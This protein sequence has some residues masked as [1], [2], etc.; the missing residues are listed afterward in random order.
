MAFAV[1]HVRCAER[2]RD[3]RLTA[4]KKNK[5][6]LMGVIFIL[7]ILGALA[8]AEWYQLRYI[9]RIREGAYVINSPEIAK[10]LTRGIEP[11]DPTFA[12]L[13]VE[14]GEDIYQRGNT[15]YVGLDRKKIEDAYPFFTNDGNAVMIVRDSS[16]L[17]DDSFEEATTYQG[18]Y[19]SAGLSFNYD[20]VQADDADYLFLK[21]ENGLY[22][23]AQPIRFDYPG[24]DSSV[25][26]NSVFY[27]GKDAVRYY[28]VRKGDSLEYGGVPTV[29]MLTVTIG[30]KTYSYEQFLNLLGIT[31]D[32][33]AWKK[34]AV[35]KEETAAA[36]LPRPLKETE[37]T[38]AFLPEEFERLEETQ[39]EE[40]EES[41]EEENTDTER[42]KAERELKN[43]KEKKKKEQKKKQN[44]I[45]SKNTGGQTPSKDTSSPTTE[46]P[47]DP[48][49]EIP[50]ISGNDVSGSDVSGNDAM[51]RPFAE[52]G[53][54][55]EDIYSVYS[56]LK[57]SDPSYTLKRVEVELFW[58]ADPT[59]ANIGDKDAYQ[60][61][62][63]KSFRT[64][65]E[66]T[67]DNL[68][69]DT[70]MYAR[71]VV[72]YSVEGETKRY[73]F[74][75][76]LEDH[77]DK[78]IQTKPLSEMDDIYVNFKDE[79]PMAGEGEEPVKVPANQMQV[80]SFRISGPNPNVL[81]RVQSIQIEVTPTDE[82][83]K[84]NGPYL[85]EMIESAGLFQRNYFYQ[86][87]GGTWISDDTKVYLPSSM[88]FDYSIALYDRFGNAIKRVVRGYYADPRLAKEDDS[89]EGEQP[90]DPETED[91]GDK[92]PV[93]A[94]DW[95]S[96]KSLSHTGEEF[97]KY[98]YGAAE[99]D[100][101]EL[102]GRSHTSRMAP[103]VTIAQKRFEDNQPN[104]DRAKFEIGIRDADGTILSEYKG[105]YYLTILRKNAD[106]VFVPFEFKSYAADGVTPVT[107]TKQITEG[108]ETKEYTIVKIADANFPSGSAAD[109]ENSTAACIY[110]ILGLTAGCV[111]EIRVYGNYDLAD[112]VCAETVTPQIW[113]Q[114]FLTADLSTYGNVAYNITNKHIKTEIWPDGKTYPSEENPAVNELS[115]YES[116]TAQ[117]ISIELNSIQ[118]SE[119]L[120]ELMTDMQVKM[121][122]KAESGK[123]TTAV[124]SAA[125]DV[126]KM[127]EVMAVNT[128]ERMWQLVDA[129]G[130]TGRFPLKWEEINADRLLGAPVFKEGKE[131]KLY[132]EA[133]MPLPGEQPNVWEMFASGAK[134]VIRFEDGTLSSNTDYQVNM[135]TWAF[136]G[137]TYHDVSSRGAVYKSREFRTL[138][139][140]PYVT[141][142]YRNVLMVS[143]YIE[144]PEIR[145][146]DD[147]NAIV[148]GVLSADRTVLQ[149]A[150]QASLE[151]IEGFGNV[152][153]TSYLDVDY[154]YGEG[155]EKDYG[156]VCRMLEYHGLINGDT[157]RISL[158]PSAIIRDTKS[159]DYTIRR[160]AVYT[161]EFVMGSGLDG[162]IIFDSITFP[163]E[164]EDENGKALLK[165]NYSL[166]DATDFTLGE[167]GTDGKIAD[168]SDTPMT[169]GNDVMA[170]SPFIEVEPGGIYNIDDVCGSSS[171]GEIR[172]CFYANKDA[173]N[174][175]HS[176]VMDRKNWE[177]TDTIVDSNSNQWASTYRLKRNGDSGTNY[178]NV[179][180][181]PEGIHYIRFMMR[182]I[183]KTTDI[184]AYVTA[185]CFK[186]KSG[187]ETAEDVLGAVECVMSPETTEPYHVGGSEYIPVNPS[188]TYAVVQ[189]YHWYCYTF[190]NG[191]KAQVSVQ[192]TTLATLGKVITV[193]SNAKFMK[194]STVNRDSATN[195]Y[196]TLNEKTLLYKVDK[197]KLNRLESKDPE[198]FY[199]DFRVRVEDKQNNLIN[200][201]E[202]YLKV[203]NETDGRYVNLADQSGLNANDCII[204][205]ETI[206]GVSYNV[207]ELALNEDGNETLDFSEALDYL[208]GSH[209]E[210][211][212]GLYVRY[213]GKMIELD[214]QTMQTDRELLTIDS[215]KSM[216]RLARYPKADFLVV[217]DI[218]MCTNDRVFNQLDATSTRTAPV[219]FEGTIDF[220]GHTLNTRY[221][222]NHYCFHG[223]SHD[224]LLENIVL[225][226]T[227]DYNVVNSEMDKVGGLVGTSYGTIRN[228]VVNL[229]L[230]RENYARQ[231][232]SA[233]ICRNNYGLIENFSLNY[234]NSSTNYVGSFFGGVCRDNYGTIRNGYAYTEKP[235]ALTRGKYGG[236]ST[237]SVSSSGLVCSVNKGTLENIYTVGDVA[238]ELTSKSGNIATSALLTG[239]D[240]ADTTDGA[241]RNC[242]SVGNLRK[243]YWEASGDEAFPYTKKTD[244]FDALIP[245]A[246][247]RVNTMVKNNYF[248]SREAANYK[249]FSGQVNKITDPVVFRDLSFYGRT[250]NQ[251]NAFHL[252]DVG[253]GNFPR[254]EMQTDMML[255]QPT[256]PLEKTEID[257]SVRYLYAEDIQVHYTDDADYD[258]LEGGGYD[259]ATATLVFQNE[260]QR[261]IDY[262]EAESLLFMNPG[263]D[264]N[265]CLNR[266]SLV[267]LKSEYQQDDETSYKIKVKFAVNPQN[268]RYE[269]IYPV[270]RFTYGSYTVPVANQDISVP[271]YKLVT[272]D[273][274]LMVFTDKISYYRLGTDIDFEKAPLNTQKEKASKVLVSGTFTGTL[275]GRGKTIRNFQFGGLGTT[276]LPYM[277][278][279]LYGT[280]KDIR[281][282]NLKMDGSG[283]SSS[284]YGI[285][286]VKTSNQ[287]AKIQ[288][289]VLKDVEMMN[290]QY[291][292]GALVSR[293]YRTAIEDCVIS[294]LKMHDWNP[295]TSGYTGGMVGS[296]ETNTRISNCLVRNIRMDLPFL[297]GSSG[298]GAL[299]GYISADCTIDNC[300]T[301][302]YIRSRGLNIGGLV[303]SNAGRISSCWTKVD[304]FTERNPIGGIV[305]E[306]SCNISRV[307]SVGNL[308][309]ANNTGTNGTDGISRIGGSGARSRC[310]A[311]KEQAVN[312]V[313]S[314]SVYGATG[315][316]GIESLKQETT[317]WET[318][319]LGA[320]FDCSVVKEGY[321][322]LLK[323]KDGH[324]LLPEQDIDRTL[325]PTE[326]APFTA[327]GSAEVM[328]QADWKADGEQNEE[329]KTADYDLTVSI[330]VTVENLRASDFVVN[331]DGSVSSFISERAKSYFGEYF[332]NFTIEGLRFAENDGHR[333]MPKITFGEG[334][335][336]TLT[337]EHVRAE[338]YSDDYWVEWRTPANTQTVDLKFKTAGTETETNLYRYIYRAKQNESVADQFAET[339]A[340]NRHCDPNSWEGAMELGGDNDE[341]FMIMADLDFSFI[342]TENKELK[343]DL[344]INRLEGGRNYSAP[345]K[346]YE[347]KDYLMAD[348]LKAEGNYYEIANLTYTTT[349]SGNDGS[350]IYRIRR[351]MSYLHFKNIS[352][353]QACTSNFSMAAL[354]RYQRAPISYIDISDFT[355]TYG[356]T[357][358]C[359]TDYAGFIGDSTS[360]LTY[361]RG[362]D[363]RIQTPNTAA[364]RNTTYVGG[365]A[366][367][368]TSSFSHIGIKGTKTVAEDGSETWS[369]E[370]VGSNTRRASGSSTTNTSDGTYTGGINGRCGSIEYSYADGIHVTGNSYTGGLYGIVTA[371]GLAKTDTTVDGL[372]RPGIT[373]RQTA[374]EEDV[375]EKIYLAEV[376]N[377][378]IK[379]GYSAG[380]LFGRILGSSG[381]QF[382]RSKDN[383][384]TSY[385]RA[386]GI[387]GRVGNGAEYNMI[388][389]CK[390]SAEASR[391]GGIS[392]D[393]EAHSSYRS[394]VRNC[395]ISA[396]THVGGI[397]P[398]SATSHTVGTVYN[399]A[400]YANKW[401]GGIYAVTC[402]GQ[403]YG[404][405]VKD[406]Y[407][408]RQN[409]KHPEV[410]KSENADGSVV[411]E[412]KWMEDEGNG[413]VL[414]G[415]IIGGSFGTRLLHCVVEDDVEIYG[416]KYVGGVLGAGGG[417][418]GKNSD[419]TSRYI[420]TGAK[421]HVTEKY[422]G[423]YAGLLVT[424]ERYSY[425]NANE[426]PLPVTRLMDV[427]V[428]G[429]VDGG[430][431]AEWVGGFVGAYTYKRSPKTA[432]DIRHPET[433][434]I[435]QVVDKTTGYK[436]YISQNNFKRIV[437][438]VT[439]V[440][441]KVGCTGLLSGY[442][443]GGAMYGTDADPDYI[444]H[445]N[446]SDI[447]D[448]R[449]FVQDRQSDA[450]EIEIRDEKGTLTSVD[451]RG[452]SGLRIFGGT[453]I[454]G[455]V[456]ADNGLVKI[457]TAKATT[458]GTTD[459]LTSLQKS[460]HYT[461][462]TAMAD[463]VDAMYVTTNDLKSIDFYYAPEANGGLNLRGL[464]GSPVY[465]NADG[466]PNQFHNIYYEAD[467]VD[468]ETGAVFPRMAWSNAND[469]GWILG[470]WVI[471]D[472][473]IHDGIPI[474]TQ[475]FT[476]FAAQNISYALDHVA[477]YASDAGSINLELPEIL[478]TEGDTQGGVM[479]LSA[480]VPETDA[481]MPAKASVK[482]SVKTKAAEMKVSTLAL[483]DGNA[484]ETNAPASA[485]ED[486][487]EVVPES[488]FQIYDE[489]GELLYQDIVGQR[490]YT[491]PYDFKS[492]LT[493]KVLAGDEARSYVV[494]G[495]SA[496]HTVMTWKDHCYY[497]KA[498]GVYRDKGL[499]QAE[500]DG[501]ENYAN[502]EKVLSGSFVHLYGGKA[503]AEDGSIYDVVSGKPVN[504]PAEAELFVPAE[505][506]KAAY[507]TRYGKEELLTYRLYT[508]TAEEKVV[509]DY[510]LFAHDGKLFGMDP[511]L[512]QPYGENF[513]DFVAD[514]YATS[515]GSA[516][517]LSALTENGT[518]TDYRTP[519]NWPTDEKQQK[520]LD[521]YG[522][523]EV[524]DNLRSDRSYV[525]IRYEN[526]VVAAFDYLTG[527]LLFIDDTEKETLDFVT[528][529]DIW[530]KGKKAAMH[531]A[532]AYI[533]A[534]G[535]LGELLEDPVDDEQLV[536]YVNGKNEVGADG[537]PEGILPDIAVD[538][539]N[540]GSGENRT[541]TGA[542]STGSSLETVASTGQ[543]DADSSI[544]EEMAAAG[545]YGAGETIS[546]GTSGDAAGNGIGTGH[547]SVA[548][549]GSD[550][551][552]G[553]G[554][555]VGR[556]DGEAGMEGSRE[557]GE[558]Y[559]KADGGAG[560]EG[561]RENGEALEKA[562]GMTGAE[563]ER[564]ETSGS[565]A[566]GS[567]G[568]EGGTGNSAESGT[569]RGDGTGAEGGTGRGDG[570]GAESGTGHEYGTGAGE[571]SGYG[572]EAE[573]YP[574]LTSDLAYVTMLTAEG[575]G[576]EIFRASELLNRSGK[577]LLSENQKLKM[578]EANGI[579]RNTVDLESM[580]LTEEENRTGI[581]LVGAVAVAVLLLLGLLYY[582][583]RKMSRMM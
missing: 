194:I 348:D 138:K 103:S 241:V 377:S 203:Y 212:M 497:L 379:G 311:A 436:A 107:E 139:K 86:E 350:W 521:N 102:T 143:D 362:R 79:Y 11:E 398:V 420:E 528:Y 486:V 445:S 267:K 564:R 201:R 162:D 469:P 2:D 65:G 37:E 371:G 422:G 534:K 275:D 375:D 134:L 234:D 68:P 178:S 515:Q 518:L 383:E 70:R 507:E 575:S 274:W 110:D 297:R 308:Y 536:G 40:K 453:T 199:N 228:V 43:Q 511:A 385:E 468:V 167:L 441:G 301:Q 496:R 382:C 120:K 97:K 84:G 133:T 22:M 263:D 492:T 579:R 455:Q 376:K 216:S 153:D 58:R 64:P 314:T 214:S 269:G 91:A 557:S 519:L 397:G 33:P 330:D 351:G 300:Y 551:E 434:E 475:T 552:S 323:Y 499:Y 424:Y 472:P 123:E 188:E 164:G 565:A 545:M 358:S 24:G 476:S 345:A 431:S 346:E 95:N 483:E 353:T 128:P 74:F 571:A 220:Q 136:Q 347:R 409:G 41:V 522:I 185:N 388:S 282:E 349:G 125:F 246:V 481:V 406:C 473:T 477:T 555:A 225:N 430:T 523:R 343:R 59:D 173:G 326:W 543:S 180:R 415:G 196:L 290:R 509:S 480:E 248:Y 226:T 146:H 491:I 421:V 303:G 243:M 553:T 238:V 459:T 494:T 465:Y 369:Y 151:T 320:S 61:M 340:E 31:D 163:M 462:G 229:S 57:I 427:I 426:M 213:N 304:I 137:D 407:I 578:L 13:G 386:G 259:Y 512:D 23:N 202:V 298:V 124:L 576:Y 563:G 205:Y 256:V 223:F 71:G 211:T 161:Y 306:G 177:I 192:D 451:Y 126:Q 401:V 21:L 419:T 85:L 56:T 159:G 182:G 29:N 169:N 80:F 166:Y 327:E 156:G 432:E 244:V 505:E 324:A 174:A 325:Q 69:P 7:V 433:G 147:D 405:L 54:F 354:I 131:P 127:K 116:A 4:V 504:V 482:S 286:L 5:G 198:H 309:I 77:F 106:D 279:T 460:W 359:A 264:M 78:P 396:G 399:C 581:L 49:G 569:G 316:L 365:I 423:G 266:G 583:K 582:K 19:V 36:P 14:K 38:P 257:V 457:C 448:R 132:L 490:V 370:V 98:A 535:L 487:I 355:L 179:I 318:I 525:V 261:E 537:N 402:G 235:L 403:V 67:I 471:N 247:P 339:D 39:E 547:G 329:N 112:G 176:T 540:V 367:Y 363:I 417:G 513:Q 530:V 447:P 20:K 550:A 357:G 209:K 366:A 335:K 272:Q 532:N 221:T 189:G 463:Y 219:P 83:H 562:D 414:A 558:A 305:G 193:P 121:T 239:C 206:D 141:V 412:K 152:K 165:S 411:W 172:V 34:K 50:A 208:S 145:F 524:G 458:A 291:Y 313:K 242:F 262:F 237:K 140:M 510:R 328:E 284:D 506:E 390:I 171:T 484:V 190:Y 287:G 341:N 273:N 456:A 148:G 280:I 130:S 378:K 539:T 461:E 299:S 30:G 289:V 230:G 541:E 231:N 561:S 360:T 526:N 529:V 364:D 27:F 281:F 55:T 520:I 118:T 429:K 265:V 108:G 321:L 425:K 6:I 270:S 374:E 99:Y 204:N 531:T 503:L 251:D 82:A 1:H 332:E 52:L 570:T 381:A 442:G 17:I 319:N 117:E 392:G 255:K 295:N 53:D 322:P 394:I 66:I 197:S 391:A 224:A 254:V 144:I 105:N 62:Y 542:N 338:R 479:L 60:L 580:K 104:R 8:V 450:T 88:V 48:D 207:M 268:P 485:D 395:T 218:T 361:A 336:I 400:I 42:E 449:A 389:G 544:S 292:C 94:I 245:L 129:S 538:G 277:F 195:P 89:E 428:A 495:D 573:E 466:T 73:E 384:I 572:S 566:E 15:L 288:G 368:S 554:E 44:T 344:M 217:D 240:G 296:G 46:R 227:F 478:V 114:Q 508:A 160:E 210:F 96:D 285:S 356:T 250:V 500:T 142:D 158:T 170:A 181:I 101:D 113:S 443:A 352:W 9:A 111:Y 278:D 498:D 548:A 331:S 3:G 168:D 416:R 47:A 233:S 517:Y 249:D 28:A 26:M 122:E 93:A 10:N 293:A 413:S 317:Y 200:S 271:F 315:L 527:S 175:T 559:G 236:D 149:G 302:G 546:A 489:N 393:E 533:N 437:L 215:R 87:E 404:V 410:V 574:P 568:R 35:K 474:P 438:S 516:E 560:A 253:N 109:T 312:G 187:D 464:S 373:M 307:L 150:V 32:K 334:G 92:D 435:I 51:F 260:H 567:S 75:N 191:N 493:V 342:Q 549:D 577:I 16:V 135:Q 63:R 155:D 45:A 333:T 337:F 115:P 556:A 12:L 72:V 186:L 283:Y 81:Q 488:C 454:N 119:V 444:D 310:Y 258:K 232:Y 294:N 470:A 100:D 184:P 452:I 18:M 76:G 380:G 502:T 408:G 501:E 440:T 183:N 439:S 157:Y 252:E 387:G 446:N 154:D 222:G 418:S 372:Q 25:R 467:K 514:Y 276:K 90:E